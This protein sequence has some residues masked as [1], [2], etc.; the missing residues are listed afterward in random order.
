ILI[1]ASNKN[2]TLPYTTLFRSD[3]ELTE[4]DEQLEKIMLGIPNIP[5]DSVPIG[6]DEEDNEEARSWGEKPS[7][8]FEPKP[9]W[10]VATDL[11]ILDRKSSRL[12]SS[13]VSIS[14]A[15]F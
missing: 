1:S 15:V 7:F 12:N 6:E 4:L 11:G 3:D 2:T 10:D 9:H 14:Y 8:N 5:H 13:H